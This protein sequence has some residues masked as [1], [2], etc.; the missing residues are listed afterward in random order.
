[1]IAFSCTNIFQKLFECIKKISENLRN[2]QKS[3]PRSLVNGYSFSKCEI[4]CNLLIEVCFFFHSS[5]QLL[6]LSPIPPSPGTHIWGTVEVSYLRSKTIH[7]NDLYKCARPVK[8]GLYLSE[9]TSGISER[10]L[11]Q[12]C[13]KC[14][15]VINLHTRSLIKYETNC[16]HYEKLHR[17]RKTKNGQRECTQN[18]ER[19][20]EKE[21]T[22]Q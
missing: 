16:S 19:S 20:S 5:L 9:N 7:C 17:E 3:L 11:Y 14:P 12:S 4:I 22:P 21:Y 18:G 2:F 1:M 10:V 15:S 8:N 13:Q 6:T